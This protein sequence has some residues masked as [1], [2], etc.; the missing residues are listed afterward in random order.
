MKTATLLSLVMLAGAGL[1]YAQYCYSQGDS[2]LYPSQA[3]YDY[4]DGECFYYGGEVVCEA[5]QCDWSYGYCGIYS[6][7]VVR[8][9]QVWWRTCIV[10]PDPCQNQCV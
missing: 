4:Y 9:C 6:P 1:A 2:R 3:C 10:N 8:A 7:P 5:W